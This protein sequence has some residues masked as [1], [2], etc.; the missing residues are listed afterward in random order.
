MAKLY[1]NTSKKLS[2]ALILEVNF[3]IPLTLALWA[4]KW[5]SVKR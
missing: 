2:N 1:L 5:S 4:K 3:T